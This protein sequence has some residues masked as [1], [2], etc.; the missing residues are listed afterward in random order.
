MVEHNL[1][2]VGV[3]SSNLVSRSSPHRGKPCF[4]CFYLHYLRIFRLGGRVVMQRPAKPCTPVRFRPQPPY[5]TRLSARVAKLVDARDLKSLD[6]KV[7]PVRF[8]P[9][10][11]FSYPP[12]PRKFRTVGR[13]CMLTV[14]GKAVYLFAYADGYRDPNLFPTGR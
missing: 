9:R 13:D 6:R 14:Y 1:A 4:P 3:A 11:P 8:R 5:A 12:H 7:M 10:A 2:K